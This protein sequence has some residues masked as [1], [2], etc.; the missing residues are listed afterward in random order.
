M[1]KLDTKKF[2]NQ[3]KD[4]KEMI[5]RQNPV[6]PVHTQFSYTEQCKQKKEVNKKIAMLFVD[7]AMNNVIDWQYMERELIRLYDE[8]DRLKHRQNRDRADLIKCGV[9]KPVGIKI[10]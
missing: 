5:E 9:I 3:L 1:N 4:K 7:H 2:V 10:L 8:I 6:I